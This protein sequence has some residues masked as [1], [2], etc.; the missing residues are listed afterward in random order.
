MKKAK[1][2]MAV[3]VVDETKKIVADRL[4]MFAV[5][6]TAQENYDQARAYFKLANSCLMPEDNKT[7]Y[8]LMEA[9]G[10][11]ELKE[12][13]PEKARE[14]WLQIMNSL[15]KLDD[16]NS[17]HMAFVLGQDFYGI[18][19]QKLSSELLDRAYHNM[20]ARRLEKTE[21]AILLSR[22]YFDKREFMDAAEYAKHAKEMLLSTRPD[23][24]SMLC[25]I[26]YQLAEIYRAAGETELAAKSQAEVQRLK[27][28]ID[29]LEAKRKL[30]E[31]KFG[32]TTAS[33]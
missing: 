16:K 19:D 7:R 28:I 5:Q 30:D 2:L 15:D 4:E 9:S 17:A 24:F 8:D 21:A 27:K 11:L 20:S 26:E 10:S 13:H 25:S 29:E 12:R 22:C 14:I 6:C 23:D 33:K 31:Q 3:S 32:K 18:G 1:E